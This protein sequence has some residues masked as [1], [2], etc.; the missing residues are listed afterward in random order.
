[1]AKKHV[2]LN[3]RK[4]Q[5]SGFNRK[6]AFKQEEQEEESQIE[7]SIKS[8]QV[9]NLRGCFNEYNNSYQSRYANRTIEFPSNIDIIEVHFFVTFNVSLKTGFFSKY[10]L[11]PVFYSNF[12]KTVS[13]EILDYTLFENFKSDI[14]YIISFENE[15]VPYSGEKHNLIALIY[16]FKFIDKRRKT[17]ETSDII[18]S[19][20]QSSQEVAFIQLD[21]LKS[22]LIDNE[23]NHS[24]VE[25]DELIYLKECSSEIID[26]IE[27]NFDIVQGITS[28]RALNVR[29]GM[30][31]SLRIDHGFEVEVSDNLPFVGI[32]DTGVNLIAPFNNLIENGGFNI[33][34]AS[35]TDISGHG[36]LVA[37]L[38]IFG[39]DLPASV[40]D[41]YKAK[42]K[43]LPIKV[44]HR[45]N[46]GIDF[47]KLINAIKQANIEKGVRIL[48]MSLVF[49]PK[50]YNESFSEF[51]FELDKLAYE[52][53]ILIFISVGN[54]DSNALRDLLTTDIHENHQYPDFFYKL[55]GTSEI[56]SCENTNISIPS[57]SL[58]NISVGALAG[59]VEE[60][61]NSD[62]TPSSI[63]PAYYTRKFNFDYEQKVNT[64]NLT[65]NQ[66]NKHLNKPD[67]VFDG[68]DL[69]NDNSGI[70]V[71]VDNGDFFRRTS[72]T[73]LSSP[74]IASMAAEILSLYPQLHTQSVKA[75]LINSSGYYKP[76]KLPAFENKSD[77]LKKLIGFGI[78]N[79]ERSL[80]SDNNVITMV[81]E[82]QIKP[83]EILS[84][85]IILPE[86]LKT[87]G[88]KL[89]L[90]VS[91]AYS[92][93]PDKGNHLG[94]LPLH[95]S[96]NLLKNLPIKDIA[97]KK[98][99]ETVAK[100]G[101]SWS[102][103]HFGIENILFSNAQKKE[104]RLQPN[105]I[106]NLKGEVAIAIRCLVKDN[107]DESLKN[108]LNQNNNP[109]SLV[110][111]IREELK[112]ETEY[113]LYN[114]IVAINDVN[115]IGELSSDA[116]IELDA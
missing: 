112:N 103:D 87:A 43:V 54:F 80:F 21:I 38:V 45:D 55:D 15:D 70:E 98:S 72:G 96:F 33:T 99:E 73:S 86:Y 63:Y 104:Y 64:Q 59:N 107:I 22:F 76:N 6:R 92:F 51:A 56:H 30:F 93:L 116:D 101:F 74:L 3:N 11:L 8:F 113:N 32:I 20:I 67:V 16:K 10:G 50:K 40:Q 18:V 48:N 28:S 71:L 69:F 60:G 95:I 78:P 84:I 100:K 97:N 24:F 91:L 85:P 44:L 47:P 39:T 27:S 79:K 115:I 102:E 36:T 46:D 31:G 106:Q 109:F 83:L 52:L 13:F 2:Y 89:V 114:E 110:I 68:G 111:E 75:L 17:N 61:D 9:V 81:I 65:R 37:G 62:I 57:D 7:P 14:E 26:T 53:D 105:D 58:N 82:D 108:Y 34:G 94:Y 88:N 77:L 90:N 35:N 29:P 4:S 19:T 25:S 5:Q 42:C 1:M 12:N 23:I 49:Y 66:K 41:T